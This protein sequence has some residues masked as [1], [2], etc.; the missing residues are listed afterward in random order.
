MIHKWYEYARY[1]EVCVVVWFIWDFSWEAIHII[2]KARV[3]KKKKIEGVV[4]SLSPQVVT[5]SR[6]VRAQFYSR[7]GLVAATVP[8]PSQTATEEQV[9]IPSCSSSA[10]DEDV[11]RQRAKLAKDKDLETTKRQYGSTNRITNDYEGRS[12]LSNW[13]K[14]SNNNNF[15]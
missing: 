7:M 1:E 15:I 3:H 11:S 14:K 9:V 5:P 2:K 6:D 8:Q 10:E 13:W 4:F 12:S